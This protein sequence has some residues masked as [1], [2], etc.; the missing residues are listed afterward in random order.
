MGPG[1][2][3]PRT[4]GETSPPHSAAKDQ[5]L[6]TLASFLNFIPPPRPRLRIL[7]VQL[8]VVIYTRVCRLSGCDLEA[9]SAGSLSTAVVCFGLKWIENGTSVRRKPDSTPSH[10]PRLS[11]LRSNVALTVL[12]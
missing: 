4:D 10:T 2:G 8:A 6:L 5:A 3:T 12:L 9:R 11:L 7:E 1:D